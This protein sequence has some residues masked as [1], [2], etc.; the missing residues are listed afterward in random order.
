MDEGNFGIIVGFVAFLALILIPTI[1]MQYFSDTTVKAGY[2]FMI[3]TTWILGLLGLCL[4]PLDIGFSSAI[5][6]MITIWRV[7]YW[8]TFF[9]AWIVNPI[10]KEYWA[11]GEF[12]R[13]AR[14]H[15][16]L[17]RN[18]RYYLSLGCVG[19]IGIAWIWIDKKLTYSEIEGLIIGLCNLYS[20]FYITIIL[21]KGL[22][23][24]P[25]YLWRA[26]RVNLELSDLYI[27]A[28]VL[29][30]ERYSL[31][32][33]MVSH[34]M[35]MLDIKR[36][37]Q[38]AN[39]SQY[40]NHR[41]Q[42]IM[43]SMPSDSEIQFQRHAMG[44]VD[45]EMWIRLTPAQCTTQ[46]EMEI[47]AILSRLNSRTKR[48]CLHYERK[49]SQYEELVDKAEELLCQSGELSEDTLDDS[50]RGWFRSVSQS[51]VSSFRLPLFSMLSIISFIMSALF[52]CT[53]LSTF[54]FGFM[55]TY[56]QMSLFGYVI[57]MFEGNVLWRTLS[58]S[59]PLIYLALVFF[60]SYF[61]Y[62]LP[63]RKKYYMYPRH[64]D[65]YSMLH[66]AQDNCR[67][68][69]SLCYHFY[70]LLQMNPTSY[71]DVSLN[72]FM[73]KMRSLRFL[74][75]QFNNYGPLFIVLI[76]TYHILLHFKIIRKPNLDFL[77]SNGARDT[78]RHTLLQDHDAIKTGKSL[79]DL[80]I[81]KRRTSRNEIMDSQQTP[82]P[83]LK[84]NKKK[85]ENT[86]S[87]NGSI[88]RY[89]YVEK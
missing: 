20:L 58:A 16:S 81:R 46:T 47:D 7:L 30:D 40:V 27:E 56:H 23:N 61:Q 32:I 88:S 51:L 43:D 19:F 78:T 87:V 17:V 18:T 9:L 68:Q 10:I 29:D 41:I 69:F 3:M 67:Y 62:K 25:F 37:F 48:M 24:F 52:L 63:F 86:R 66:L 11:S 31:Q 22:S 70:T 15:E 21:G 82:Y 71:K 34:K 39:K 80:S 59:V 38:E 74:G 12:T 8:I 4:Y 85:K 45:Q 44:V 54:F 57:R 89:V 77:L 76:S 6:S 84:K 72:A 64:S 49:V 33:E 60:W 28:L 75:T 26:R 13:S 79:L 35:N 55:S 36:C 14:F 2:L 73:G 42:M 83:N 53:E 65:T 5:P 50:G 1:L